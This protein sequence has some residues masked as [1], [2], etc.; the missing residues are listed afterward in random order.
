MRYFLLAFVLAV[1]LTAGLLGKQGSF[2]RKPPIE[3]F[4]DMD[5]QPKI[6]PQTPNGFFQDGKASRMPVLGTVARGSKYLDNEVNTGRTPGTTNFVATIPSAISVN[7][8]LLARGRERYA[9]SCLPCHGPVGDGNGVTKKLGMAVVGNLHDKRIVQLGDG[10]LFNTITYG[11]N[12]MGS[13]GQNIE[14]ND[15]WAII[16]YVRSLQLA[17]LGSM[18]D[19]PAPLQAK[20]AH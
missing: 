2:T 5:R 13:Y 19:L 8:T 17:R 16:A 14:V 3:V 11:K 9:I 1:A 7:A 12:L 6:R 10:E 15:R 4:P 20:L 18:A